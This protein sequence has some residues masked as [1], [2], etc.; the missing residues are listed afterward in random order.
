M[1]QLLELKGHRTVLSGKAKGMRYDELD[2]DTIKRAARRSP[3]DPELQ[4]FARTL[5]ALIELDEMS[6]EQREAPPA[7]QESTSLAVVPYKQKK[8]EAAS[9][10][11]TFTA[12]ASGIYRNT[13][14]TFARL[15]NSLKGALCLLGLY[16][17]LLLLTS[18]VLAAKGGEFAAEV[19]N[20]LVLRVIDFWQTFQLAL[21]RK[22]GLAPSEQVV[23]VPVG[24][25]LEH[26]ST[27]HYPIR[28]VLAPQPTRSAWD[29]FVHDVGTASLGLLCVVTGTL[30]IGQ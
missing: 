28:T 20:L 22:L 29:Q 2:E 12:F 30:W 1:K 9:D 27:P 14:C 17:G 19:L 13:T 18:P 23:Y 5:L 4:K 16:V 10:S 21:L 24:H 3:G 25:E 26:E 15:P 11:H 6:A 7:R 8:K